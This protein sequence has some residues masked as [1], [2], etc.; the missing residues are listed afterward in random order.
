[1]AKWKERQ[2]RTLRARLRRNLDKLQEAVA[3]KDLDD[4]LEMWL[5]GARPATGAFLERFFEGHERTR[6]R[7]QVG[8][9]DLEDGTL[10][11]DATLTFEGLSGSRRTL[12]P[13]PWRARLHGDSFLDPLSGE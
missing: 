10:V 9:A 13:H 5:P 2:D 3:S 8:N 6:L 1:M 7:F 4:A 12:D 11:F